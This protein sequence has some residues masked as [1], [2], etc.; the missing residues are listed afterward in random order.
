[1]SKRNLIKSLLVV[2]VVCS[3][4]ISSSANAKIYVGAHLSGGT[5]TNKGNFDL[6]G[7]NEKETSYFGGVGGRIGFE[8]KGAIYFATEIGATGA[9]GSLAGAVTDS[10]TSTDNPI[11][12]TGLAFK[13]G[14]NNKGNKMYAIAFTDYLMALNTIDDKGVFVLGGG[15]GTKIRIAQ[16]IDFVMEAKAGF[17]IAERDGISITPTSGM[18]SFRVVLQTGFD[19]HF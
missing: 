10:L 9:L 16:Y 13:F 5:F 18:S 19:L 2:A 7:I 17:P 6:L 3:A 1:M 8:S 4:S 11:I 12:N 15:L 14:Y